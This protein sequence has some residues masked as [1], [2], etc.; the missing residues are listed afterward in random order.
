LLRRIFRTVYIDKPLEEGFNE[1]GKLF[2][3]KRSLF[4]A[5]AGW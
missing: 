3:S 2:A 5:F 1:I 4:K